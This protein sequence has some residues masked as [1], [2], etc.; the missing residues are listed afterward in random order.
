[1]ELEARKIV[2]YFSALAGWSIRDCFSRIIQIAAILTIEK[3]TEVADLCASFKKGQK[4]TEFG[5]S[6]IKNILGLR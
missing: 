6:E 5:A 1:M 2:A 4:T 3:A